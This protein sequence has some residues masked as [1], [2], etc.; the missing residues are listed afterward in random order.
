MITYNIELN[1]ENLNQKNHWLN[2]L[3]K[4][5]EIFNYASSIVKKRILNPLLKLF[6]IDV[7]MK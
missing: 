6:M 3:E 1:F 4:S 5:T 7:I 2:L